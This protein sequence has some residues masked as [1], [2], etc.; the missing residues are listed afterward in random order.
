VGKASSAKKIAR[1]ARSSGSRRSGQRRN[2]GFPITVSLVVV[3]GLLLVGF[4]RSNQQASAHPQIYTKTG[5]DHWHAAYGIYL[6]DHFVS[7]L[8]DG[9]AGD[10]LGIHT[11]SDG[12][13]HI[14]PFVASSAGTNAQLGVFMDDTD[15]KLSNTKISLPD[16]T[17]MEEGKDKCDGKAA[18]VEV[19]YWADAAD[20]AAGK[21]PTT[22][23]TDDF[24]KIRFKQDRSAF[25]IAFLPE[26][27]KIPAPTSIP[28]LDNLTDLGTA[29]SSAPGTSGDTTTSSAPGDTG[30]STTTSAPGGTTSSTSSETTSS[31]TG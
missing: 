22:I 14:H 15:S 6:C 25:T 2:L 27:K 17:V 18:I 7:P 3:L 26:G 28:T 23:F 11:H 13:I 1:V 29:T 9:A 21:K 5:G 24:D 19:A 10:Q 30:S 16:G 12:V 4:A 20:A 8:G 31:T